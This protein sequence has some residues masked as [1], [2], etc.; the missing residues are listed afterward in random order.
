MTEKVSTGRNHHEARKSLQ[1]A[2][3][4]TLDCS[5]REL[6]TRKSGFLVG[7]PVRDAAGAFIGQFLL[8]NHNCKTRTLP[9]VAASQCRKKRWVEVGRRSCSG[10]ARFCAADKGTRQSCSVLMRLFLCRCISTTCSILKILPGLRDA[11]GNRTSC[12]DSPRQRPWLV[13]K[14]YG[15]S[16]PMNAGVVVERVCC[17]M[18]LICGREP[19][20]SL[21]VFFNRFDHRAQ[22]ALAIHIVLM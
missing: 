10:K 7:Q 20:S 3:G 13:C 17:R 9:V 19:A 18:W 6:S 22:L 2:G 8:W 16:L 4:V 11:G 1:S 5:H 15:A 14:L 21:T 12:S